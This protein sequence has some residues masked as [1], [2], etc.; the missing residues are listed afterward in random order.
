MEMLY[1]SWYCLEGQ[2]SLR[3]HCSNGIRCDPETIP[4]YSY[5][6]LCS[7]WSRNCSTKG[8]LGQR[9]WGSGSGRSF[10]EKQSPW[11][12]ACDWMTLKIGLSLR[13]QLL[14]VWVGF[15]WIGPLLGLKCSAEN[16]SDSFSD[17]PLLCSK[18]QH[19][20]FLSHTIP[21]CHS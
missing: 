1:R 16:V 8:F 12:K 4:V 21:V 5:R 18:N 2:N 17:V 19:L 6:P 13:G 7:F 14:Y 10:L 20:P 11:M 15:V 3:P 9:S